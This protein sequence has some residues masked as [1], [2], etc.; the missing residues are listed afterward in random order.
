MAEADELC[1]RIAIVDHGR[2]LAIGTPDELKRRVQRESIFRLELDR[3]DGGTAALARLPGVD[4]RGAR[5]RHRIPRPSASSS[6]SCSRTTA[7]WAASSPRSAGS[8]RPDPRAAQV[9]AHPRGRVRE[10]VGRGFAD[11][12][13]RGDARHRDD[14]GAD[15]GADDGRT[16]AADQA[17]GR[18][19]D[20]L[21]SLRARRRPGGALRGG[22]PMSLPPAPVP[23]RPDPVFARSRRGRP[24]GRAGRAAVAGTTCA[25][26]RGA[27]TRAS[28]A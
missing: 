21:G 25:R 4:L 13:D 19:A 11:E 7:H 2:I 1:E 6:T 14:A 28:G 5:R 9:R 16:T 26:S 20:E 3:L 18:R 27:P 23:T 17:V 24:R 15:A 8:G 22:G 10:L 12:D